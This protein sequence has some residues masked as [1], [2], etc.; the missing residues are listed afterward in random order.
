MTGLCCDTGVGNK[1][2]LGL[3]CGDHRGSLASSSS[4]SAQDHCYHGEEGGGCCGS[5]LALWLTCSAGTLWILV[6]VHPP[7]WAE[8]Q[9]GEEGAVPGKF[10]G[11]PSSTGPW[12]GGS[13]ECRLQQ[14]QELWEPPCYPV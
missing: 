10:S 12:A 14:L 2:P 1:H 4:S 11:V 7:G 13:P 6:P 8:P 9:R 5:Q 3:R